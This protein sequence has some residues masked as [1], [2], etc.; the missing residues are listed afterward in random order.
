[1]ERFITRNW[2]AE[3]NKSSQLA[4]FKLETQENPRCHFGLVPKIWEPGR[5]M[6]QISV[7][8][9]EKTH[10]PVYADRQEAKGTNDS[11]LCLFVLF[12]PSK[13]WMM[14]IHTGENT[15]S[16]T[17]L[18]WEYLHTYTEKQCFTLAPSG[19]ITLTHET[20]H[21]PKE[22]IRTYCLSKIK[23]TGKINCGEI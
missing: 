19:S 9:Q 7:Q 23:D 8:G 5:L 3:A 20:N 21:H 10:I 17:N 18:I 13:A 16:N 6:V 1:M 4:V 15:E 14:P 12:R 22:D 2:V 11:L